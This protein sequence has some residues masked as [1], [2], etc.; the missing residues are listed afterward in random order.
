[1]NFTY[2]QPLYRY[3]TARNYEIVE[4]HLFGKLNSKYVQDWHSY[5][6]PTIL[7]HEYPVIENCKNSTDIQMMNIIYKKYYSDGI[8]HY[9]LLSSDSDF[10]YILTTLPEDCDIFVAYCDDKVSESYISYLKTSKILHVE[11]NTMRGEVTDVLRGEIVDTVLA[12]Y[13]SFK[14]G[15]EFFNYETLLS[16]IHRRYGDIGI[17]TASDVQKLCGPKALTFN[18]DG[19]CIDGRLVT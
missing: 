16:W 8:K 7:I 6:Q 3:L 15:K 18:A 14:L 2:F 1:M 9:C 5:L 13:L 12:S 19:V 4:L 11:M 10:A 17:N